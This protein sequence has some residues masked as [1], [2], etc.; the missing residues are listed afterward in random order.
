MENFNFNE[1]A[2]LAKMHPGEFDQRR[3]DVVESYISNSGG[4][5]RMHR[6]QCR[7]DSEGMCARTPLKSC[8]RLSTLMWDALNS[9]NNALTAFAEGEGCEITDASFYSAR[10]ARIIH[11]PTVYKTFE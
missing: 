2:L 5:C 7:I 1:R 6:L 9:F 8:F 11:V 3:N 4:N 10:S